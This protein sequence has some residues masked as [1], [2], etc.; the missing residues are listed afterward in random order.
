MPK[1]RILL[2]TTFFFTTGICW[3][4]CPTEAN[5]QAASGG[6]F[7]ATGAPGSTCTV[8]V[9]TSV[10]ING[11][12][13]WDG[14]VL[15]ISG[16][17][18][19]VGNIIIAAG[20]SLTIQNGDVFAN[21]GSSGRIEVQEG[22]TLI[23][24]DGVTL[25]SYLALDVFGEVQNNGTIT[26]SNSDMSIWA[27]GSV[28]IGVG[29]HIETAGSGDNEIYGILDVYGSL[30]TN[31]DLE[32]DGGTVTVRSG[33]SVS[34]GDPTGPA[35]DNDLIVHN[36]GLVLVEEG[37][38]V[39]VEDDI[40][41]GTD[42]TPVPHEPTSGAIILDGIIEGGDDLFVY[43]TSAG[44]DFC[45]W[46]TIGVDGDIFNSECPGMGDFCGCGGGGVVCNSV[47]P[48]ELIE[49]D[50]NS[51]NNEVVLHW[52]TASELDNDF[53]SVL[54]SLDAVNFQVISTLPGHGTTSSVHEYQMTDPA[55][56]FG[57]N[58]YKLRQTDYNGH[59]TESDIIYVS[60]YANGSSRISVFPNPI[61]SGEPLQLRVN[62]EVSQQVVTGSFFDVAGKKLSDIEFQQT[63]PQTYSG[64]PGSAFPCNTMVFLRL[65]G[66]MA[67]GEGILLLIR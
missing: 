67:T 65:N 10:T 26:V 37:A 29:G 61:R 6:T 48:V 32:V 28:T 44:C 25:T 7:T 57:S 49:F 39:S 52:K 11:P 56:S 54:R 45:G 38:A 2:A 12:V 16:G 15:N 18:G 20:G 34:I 30:S 8:D 40:L 50:G 63:S 55:P 19:S 60:H 23:L 41:V 64:L 17:A 47:L 58:Y 21:D 33:A 66:E 42:E 13:V 35:A 3:S 51:V 62:A 31:A 1:Q 5:L 22:G 14:G 46:G 59:W 9:G 4:Q 24:S 36:G 43:D 53:F 27:T